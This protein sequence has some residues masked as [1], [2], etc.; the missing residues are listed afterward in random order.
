MKIVSAPRS[1]RQSR[2]SWISESG[3][4]LENESQLLDPNGTAYA[5]LYVCPTYTVVAH[6]H[7][8][9]IQSSGFC[10]GAKANGVKFS[11]VIAG[12][13]RAKPIPDRKPDWIVR[14]KTLPE[15]ALIYRLSGDYNP[16]HIGM[17][18]SVV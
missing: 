13:P 17:C 8:N 9:L 15:Q 5:K 1:A 4:V 16:L 2:P 6:S 18:E 12:S 14:E 11:K 3:I 10:L 7:T